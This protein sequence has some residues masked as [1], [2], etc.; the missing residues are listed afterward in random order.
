M[1]IVCPRCGR[2][3]DVILFDFRSYLNCECGYRITKGDLHRL[4]TLNPQVFIIIPARFDSKRL[5][6]KPL[7]K[8]KGKP[9]IQHVY[10]NASKCTLP[11]DIVVATDDI[12]ILKCVKGFGGRTIMTKKDHPTGTDRLAEAA[13]ILNLGKE[14][15]VINIQGDMPYFDPEIIEEVAA[16]LI[17]NSF[18]P[19]ATLAQ[20]IKDLNEINDPNCVKVVL[21]K[22]YRALYFSRISIPYYRGKLFPTY[23]KHLGIY[24]YRKSFLDK[25]VKLSQT[26][27]ERAEK[28]EQLRALEH[29]YPI[30]V[31]ITKHQAL[32]VN[33]PDDLKRLKNK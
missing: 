2:Q 11:E 20:E 10:E 1:A 26:P 27:L 16:P 33:T 4:Y 21:T 6:G 31:V 8:I 18:L 12:R 29:G 14:D 17:K 28:L 23:Y 13:N 5:P 19:M 24:A 9:I 22:T 7:V 15:V 3:Y 25:Y 32:D 30:Q